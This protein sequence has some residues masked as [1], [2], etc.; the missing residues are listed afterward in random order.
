MLAQHRLI[1]FRFEVV[2]YH[3]CSYVVGV[4]IHGAVIVARVLGTRQTAM[5][6]LQLLICLLNGLLLF[7][8]PQLLRHFP[9]RLL[10]LLF[11]LPL[12][13]LFVLLLLLGEHYSSFLLRILTGAAHVLRDLLDFL[14]RLK[15]RERLGSVIGLELL[16]V[17]HGFLV[18][19]L[20]GL[21]LLPILWRDTRNNHRLE[22]I[23]VALLLLS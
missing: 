21:H 23:L 3:K 20:S 7:D 2:T 22:Q 9:D 17:L 10:P 5:L 14:C 15:G 12:E 19:I 1:L 4:G 8:D 16:Q 13:V 11:F 6:L 18:L